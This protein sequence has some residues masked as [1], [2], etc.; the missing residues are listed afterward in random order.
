MKSPKPKFVASRSTIERRLTAADP[1]LGRVIATVAARI[2]PQGVLR[3]RATPF[4][5]LVRAVVYQSVSGKAAASIF[6]RFKEIAGKPLAPSTVMAR[7]PRS[8][9][10]A[11]LPPLQELPGD[12]FEE[13]GCAGVI[14][15]SRDFHGLDHI[16][17]QAQVA[18]RVRRRLHGCPRG[19]RR[20]HDRYRRRAAASAHPKRLCR[21]ATRVRNA[22]SWNGRE[23]GFDVLGD[24]GRE[25]AFG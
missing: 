12:G 2:G 21:P 3:S 10:Q 23:V 8:L 13:F 9:M 17:V 14:L 25:K 6:A 11:G 22:W 5:A 7:R 19:R 24:I 1:A 4:E 18:A 20:S 16:N 15:E